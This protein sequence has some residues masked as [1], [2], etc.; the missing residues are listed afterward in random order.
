MRVA[1]RSAWQLALKRITDLILC[2][3]ATI[4]LAPWLVLIA[5][6]IVIDS[7]GSPIFVQKRVGRDG[8]L[9]DILKFR[10]MYTGTP[11]VE[12]HLMLKMQKSPVT[13]VG[14]VLRK[15][16]LDELPQ[17]INVILG[18]MSLVGP[19]PALY[20]Q[21]ELTEARKKAGVLT[22]RPGI[23]GWAQINGRDDLPDDKK[24]ELD[25]WYCMQWHYFL[26]WKIIG[27]T[28]VEVIRRRGAM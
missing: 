23:T 25:A 11:N 18:Q 6:A 22:M 3:W 15:T 1:K 27:L 13:R 12:T 14:A 5:L 9:F 8:R 7:P 26:D 28:I 19:R 21:Y 10:T 24:I 16:S 2:V 17:L 4:V 20:N